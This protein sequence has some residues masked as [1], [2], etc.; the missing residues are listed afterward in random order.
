MTNDLNSLPLAQFYP[1]NL[2]IK[3][4]L[5]ENDVIHIEMRSQTKKCNCPKCMTESSSMH[6]TH[7]RKVQD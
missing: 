7:H 2:L 1:Q 4:V 3:S 5:T 6:A